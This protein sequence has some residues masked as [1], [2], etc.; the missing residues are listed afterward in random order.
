M[1]DVKRSIFVNCNKNLLKTL[2]LK[3]FKNDDL[4][5]FKLCDIQYNDVK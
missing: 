5:Y 3:Q 4:T 1:I 2:I